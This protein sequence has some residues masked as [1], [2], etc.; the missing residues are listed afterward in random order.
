MLG[1]DLSRE[2][3]L[4][5]E[6]YGIDIIHGPRATVRGF[7]EADITDRNSISSVIKK[8][9][10]GIVIHA[11]AWK[12]VDDCEFDK[13]KAY[14]INAEAVKNVA[15]ASKE[16]GATLVYI[17]TD[18]V[19]N[20]KKKNPYKETDRAD[21]ISI[22]GASK[23]KGEKAVKKILK[24]Y[25]IIRTSWLYGKYGK[26][27]VDT[28]ISNART[29]KILKVADDQ[30]G[31]PTYTK[32]LAK[33]IRMLLKDSVQPSYGI[34]HITNSGS[35]SWYEYAKEILKL[36]KS[37]TKVRAISSDELDR[38]ARRPG[39]SILDNSKFVKLTGYKMRSWKRALKEYLER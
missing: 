28:I 27:F 35:V 4:D 12:D 14:A 18:F 9:R 34:Y 22:Y 23:L 39:M 31:S 3:Q 32:D 17:S 2:L 36:S 1:I 38:P 30:V 37:G 7:Q 10:P 8:I 25:F 20:G 16:I 29:E 33:A 26:N 11:A 6:V 15:Q 19:F 13:K 5:Y 24:R 21:P